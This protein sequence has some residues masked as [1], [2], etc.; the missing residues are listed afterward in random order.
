MKKLSRMLALVLALALSVTGL[1]MA[2]AEPAADNSGDPVLFTFDGENVTLSQV[3]AA[4]NNMYQNGYV[5]DLADYDTAIQSLIQNKAVMAK[6]SELGFDQFTAEEEDA[7]LADAQAEWDDALDYY[8]S[9]FLTEDTDEARA[10][11]REQAVAYYN[12]MGYDL[13]VLFESVKMS[14]SYD[15]LENYV[16][17]S[18]DISVSEGDILDTFQ[19][20][21]E[22]DQNMYEGNIFNYEYYVLYYG[23]D[24]WYVPEGYRGIIHILLKA[25]DDLIAAYTTAQS[26]YEDALDAE[27]PDQAAIDQAKA[28]VDAARD[29]ILASKKDILDTIYDRLEK[30][31]EFTVLIKEYGEDPGM[32]DEGNLNNGYQVHAES[33]IWDAAFTAGAFSEKMQKPGDYSD[34]VVGQNGI[35]IL[36]YLRDIPSGIVELNDSIREEIATYLQDSKANELLNNAMTEWVAQHEVAY[37]DDAIAAAKA[38]KAASAE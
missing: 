35:H 11:T 4:L 30:G 29:A 22:N 2:F 5:E 24:S 19:Q 16:L 3:D 36:Y 33:I 27:T 28:T 18:A 14:A 37:N 17:S 23:Y 12:A 8:V 38:A 26:A 25:D 20:Y 32:Q 15:K 21:A 1:T 31:E 13:D 6:I 7:L 34:P 10:A 9:Y